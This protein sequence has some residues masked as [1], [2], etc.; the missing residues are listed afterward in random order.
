MSKSKTYKLQIELKD[1]SG[2]APG[3]SQIKIEVGGQSGTIDSKNSMTCLLEEVALTTVITITL[4]KGT[5]TLGVC[6]ISFNAMFGESLMRKAEKW[7][8]LKEINPSGKDLKVKLSA[9]LFN[10][11]SKEKT[12]PIPKPSSLEPTPKEVK[13]VDISLDKPRS[14]E[15]PQ[16]PYM[17]KVVTQEIDISKLNDI[18]KQREIFGDLEHE[19]SIRITLE[20]E[21]INKPGTEV[22]LYEATTLDTLD[23]NK[24]REVGGYQLKKM[25]KSL[26]EEVKNGH[27]SSMNLVNARNQFKIKVEERLQKHVQ[28]E[29]LSESILKT[30]T[31][32]SKE[33][34]ELLSQRKILMEQLQSEEDKFRAL[35]LDVD[36]AKSAVGNAARENIR[37]KAECIRYG[38]A[39]KVH[40]ELQAQVKDGLTR[41]Q[42]LEKAFSATESQLKTLKEKSESQKEN[43]RKEKEELASTLKDLLKRKE[44]SMK[45]NAS[46]K[47]QL[48]EVKQR[49]GSEQNIKQQIKEARN[50][51][52]LESSKRDQTYY[53]LQ[54]FTH[55]MQSQIED[56]KLKQK[57]LTG[58]RKAVCQSISS[59]EHDL[60]NKQNQIIDLKRKLCEGYSNQITLEQMYCIK[61]DISQIIDELNKLQ[62]VHN[63]GREI[64]LKGLDHGVDYVMKES[65]QVIEDTHELDAM[66]DAL[67]NKDYELDNLKVMVG[68]AK[69]RTAPYVPKIDDPV[70]VALSEYL[71]SLDEPI[72]IPFTRENEGVYLFGTKRIFLK[73]ENNNI[74]IRVGGGYTNIEEFIEIYTT[75]EL[76]RQEENVEEVAPQAAETLTRFTGKAGMSPQRAARIIH[77]SVEA[78]SQGS[79][80]K[81]SIRKKV[82]K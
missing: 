63:E 54:D 33:L 57:T 78:L 81:A 64:I 37:L 31:E 44:S 66:I 34:A 30:S 16:C 20:P 69:G 59:L 73:L 23:M 15:G 8:R 77:S 41:K 43:L 22:V 40:K 42:N 76:E 51:S 82:Q 2:V 21:T 65:E 56:F 19:K 29:N 49:M 39:D 14:S 1:I 36:S 70:D 27:Y 58:N 50:N 17:A 80:L 79:P 10:Q 11:S 71:N 74:R 48:A 72:P 5:E 45:E 75:T 62:R 25:L 3:A 46:L 6:R 35:E 52:T 4:C 28:A 26:T 18:W 24:L 9:S 53:D 7:V 32:K 67:D 61:S 38:D 47:K 68:E 13:S 12:L 55:Q 60:E